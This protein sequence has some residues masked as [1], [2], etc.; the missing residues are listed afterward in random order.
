MSVVNQ[1]G[2]FVRPTWDYKG[3]PNEQADEYSTLEMTESVRNVL[4]QVLGVLQGIQSRLDCHETLQIP[5][6]LRQIA[7]QTKKRKYKR[8]GVT[9]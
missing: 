4:E 3:S 2:K 6:L 5:R 7:K 1:R 9:R 8:K